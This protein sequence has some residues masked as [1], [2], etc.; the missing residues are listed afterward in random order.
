MGEIDRMYDINELM[1]LLKIGKRTLHR[2]L[3]QQEIKGV[4]IGGKW[5]VSET[6][7]KDFLRRGLSESYDSGR[8]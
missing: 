1:D 3:R 7:L 4:K 2:Y 5:I 6:E 8:K